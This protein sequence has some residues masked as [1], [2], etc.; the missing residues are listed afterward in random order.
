MKIKDIPTTIKLW[1]GAGIAV[2]GALAAMGMNIDR[3]AWASELQ[4]IQE[5]VGTNQRTIIQMQ[6]DQLN[7]SIWMQEDRLKVSPNPDGELRKRE[8]IEHRKRMEE[9]LKKLNNKENG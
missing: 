1:I 2:V 6:I 3:M 4:P 8:M 9:R 5:Q 7:R